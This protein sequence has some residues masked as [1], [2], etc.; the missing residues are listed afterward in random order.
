MGCVCPRLPT[1]GERTGVC[2]DGLGDAGVDDLVVL[3]DGT[4]PALNP[5]LKWKS[6]VARLR[7]DASITLLP[8][9]SSRF[10][11]GASIVRVTLLVL[12]GGLLGRL[13]EALCGED[14]R[15]VVCLAPAAPPGA[16]GPFSF[17]LRTALAAAHQLLST[18]LRRS[19]SPA[20]SLS[21]N[22]RRRMPCCERLSRV[23]ASRSI[24]N[25]SSSSASLWV[26]APGCG[27]CQGSS[28]G[29]SADP[30]SPSIFASW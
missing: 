24:D 13:G 10:G 3:L 18:S 28:S 2:A 21:S 11:D 8:S 19:S 5:P 6:K 1:E 20:V 16:P 9:S 22:F 23:F 30:A 12:L 4:A 15:P 26:T 17:D 29:S 27:S 25:I 14:A 7:I